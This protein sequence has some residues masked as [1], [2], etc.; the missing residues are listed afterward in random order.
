MTRSLGCDRGGGDGPGRPGDATP[1][2]VPKS[3]DAKD[4]C[5]KNSGLLVVL[6]AR[7]GVAA[8]VVVWWWYRIMGRV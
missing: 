5:N 8:V 6:D 3:I 7:C 2:H 1:A 4:S